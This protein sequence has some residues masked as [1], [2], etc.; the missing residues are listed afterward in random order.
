MTNSVKTGG[1]K[2][3]RQVSSPGLTHRSLRHTPLDITDLYVFRGETGAVFAI[4]V[5]HSIFG[6]SQ[7]RAIIR[8]MYELKSFEQRRD[9]RTGTHA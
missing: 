8:R 5:C 2:E 4:D 9:R 6:L 7:R 1:N 3:Q